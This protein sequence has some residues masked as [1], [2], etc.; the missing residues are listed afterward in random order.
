MDRPDGIRAGPVFDDRGDYHVWFPE[1][2]DPV[3]VTA[4]AIDDRLAVETR[5][6]VE[7]T[8]PGDERDRRADVAIQIAIELRD[9]GP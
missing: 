5:G 1:S 9:A 6:R 4:A 2:P 3:P 8:V 7:G